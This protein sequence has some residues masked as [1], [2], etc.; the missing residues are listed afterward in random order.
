[1]LTDLNYHVILATNGEEAVQLYR[2][3]GHEVD[4]VILDVVMP[5]MSG[6]TA[7]EQIRQINKQ[8]RVIFTSGFTG[9]EAVS[10]LVSAPLTV[11]LRKPYRS[12]DLQRAILAMLDNHP[13]VPA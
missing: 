1:M 7:C 2:D 10:E 5:K 4:L 8:A 12:L 13:E 3:R 11:F 9:D 6:R